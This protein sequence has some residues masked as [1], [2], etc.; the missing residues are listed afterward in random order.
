MVASR[1]R[2]T[3]VRVANSNVH[4]TALPI[5]KLAERIDDKPGNLMLLPF[6]AGGGSVRNDPFAKGALIGLT[7]ETALEDIVKAL[8]EGVTYEQAAGLSNVPEIDEQVKIFRC[9]GG[10]AR[11]PVWL[12]IKANILG[13]PIEKLNVEDAACLG[14]ALIAGCGIGVF[15]SPQTA[16]ARVIRPGQRFEPDPNKHCEYRKKLELYNC[17]ANQFARPI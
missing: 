14:A 12:R 10:G 2:E 11:S 1:L 13:R 6:F 5:E 15:D 4:P 9:G 3:F 16:V 7:F 17:L 8:L